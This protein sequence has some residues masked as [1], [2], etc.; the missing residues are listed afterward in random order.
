MDRLPA[1]ILAAAALAACDD[2]GSAP[3]GSTRRADSVKAG[4]VAAAPVEDLCDLRFTAA[5]APA[6]ALPALTGP[7]P[8][9][10]TGWRWINVWA[11]WC[12][13]CL[14]EMARLGSWQPRLAAAGH[15][16]SFV[17]ISADASDAEVS[18]YRAAHPDVPVGARLADPDALAAWATSVGLDAEA[19][20]PLHILVDPKDRVRCVRAGAVADRDYPAVLG[21]LGD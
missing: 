5:K 11:T 8:A 19:P 10:T 9:A 18:S 1:L 20:I 21:A 15:P 7:P 12:K 3:S 16:V 13:P 14:E 17:F 4:K 6:F 2:G